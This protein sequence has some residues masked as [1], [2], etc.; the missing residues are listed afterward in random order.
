[1]NNRG[2]TLIEM[3]VVSVIGLIILGAAYLLYTGALKLFKDVKTTS[4]N[5]ETK[6]PSTELISRYFDRWGAGVPGTG[7]TCSGYPPSNPKCITAQNITLA[8]GN[9]C[10][11]VMF[12][13][14]AGGLGFVTT[15][16]SGTASIISCR[17]NVDSGENC[18]YLWSS[19]TLY[20]DL[21]IYSTP[22]VLKVSTGLSPNKEGCSGLTTGNPNASA[23]AILTSYD[24]AYNPS[25]YKTAVSGDVI[26]AIPQKIRFY[27]QQNSSDENRYWLYVDLTDESCNQTCNQTDPT[28]QATCVAYRNT[29]KT[30]SGCT[31]DELASPIA[32][33]DKF[34]AQLL[35]SGCNA[36][37][38]GCSAVKV[39]ITLRSQAKTYSR[40]FKSQQFQRVFGR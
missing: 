23:S 39:D 28:E 8:N 30:L 7:S 13:G 18:Y 36:L 20:N 9:R 21:D 33:V 2:Y 25:P 17:L 14:N 31:R 1:M 15:V 12:W 11:D 38:G 27:C 3:L 19:D 29:C 32:P 22:K 5:L 16:T 6:M 37:T 4:D 10:D 34:E 40:E 26:Q 24:Y 35:P